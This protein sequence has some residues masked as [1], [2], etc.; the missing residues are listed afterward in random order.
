LL[1][2]VTDMGDK[3]LRFFGYPKDLPW[4]FGGE[5]D[6]ETQEIACRLFR[7]GT[8]RCLRLE[9]W[10]H[11]EGIEAIFL[12]ERSNRSNLDIISGLHREGIALPG[13]FACAAWSGAGFLGRHDRAWLCKPGNLHLVLGLRPHLRLDRAG[14]GFTILGPLACVN[15]LQ[16][17]TPHEPPPR[18]KWINDVLVDGRKIAGFLT[19]QTYQ[20]PLITNA[21]LGIGVNVLIDPAI[22]PNPF[23]TGTSCL[24][25]IYPG[26]N[27]TPGGFL[28]ALLKETMYWYRRLREDGS[29][30]LL[31]SYRKKSLVIGRRVRIYEDG[32][33]FAESGLEGRRLIA[34]GRVERILDD[35]SLKL[36]GIG[37]PVTAGR[38]ALEQDCRGV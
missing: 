14:C 38:L 23:V 8:F 28:L 27:W 29:R 24:A 16:E 32:F 6:L 15:A 26:I 10:A 35:L 13:T 18:I 3:A 9:G 11:P 37:D 17:I 7:P 1:N 2:I 4:E 19:R 21:L 30:T 5:T 22:P 31:A 12:V 20:D 34:R 36:E 33:G 25:G